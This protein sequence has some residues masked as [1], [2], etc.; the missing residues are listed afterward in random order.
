MAQPRIVFLRL[1]AIG[2]VVRT[3][4]ALSLVRKRFP[5]A[6]I[7]WIVEERSLSLLKGQADLDEVI[8]FERD[9]LSRLVSSPDSFFP[10]LVQGA[11]FG[12]DVRR[13]R[14]DI[15]LD[16]QGTLKSG[17]LARAI[18]AP[19]RAGYGQPWVKEGNFLFNNRRVS[20]SSEPVHRVRR[21]VALL[22]VLGITTR[23]EEGSA[24]LPIT[25]ADRT[26]ADLALRL[27]KASAGGY[28]FLYPGSSRRQ[29]YKRYP[30]RRFG[31]VAR[32]LMVAGH[33]VLVGTGP[34]EESIGRDIGDVAGE[35]L[36]S[37]PPTSLL[38]M[39]EVIRRARLFLGGD[40]GPMHMASVLGVPIVSLFGPTDP[41][42]NAPW[43]EGHVVLDALAPRGARRTLTPISAPL[44]GRP[45]HRSL[46]PS[47]F[48]PLEPQ[49]IVEAALDRLSLD[50]LG[51]VPTVGP[52][53]AED[54][55]AGG[56]SKSMRRP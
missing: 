5:E 33:Q 3:L 46:D 32:A 6:S 31:E 56:I 55:P 19:V 27:A 49:E 38:V 10:G 47:T 8:L 2:D 13:R 14:F 4:P 24:S 20:L 40:T 15:S 52:R 36:R 29:Q 22:E 25:D 43:G 41:L 12:C 50:A 42:L 11:R 26:G 30:A 37:L 28:I 18:G 45:V 1:G 16:F 51:T 54:V 17:L 35:R 39:A 9:R 34:S 21:N 44:A 48:D 53:H 7:A 23:A